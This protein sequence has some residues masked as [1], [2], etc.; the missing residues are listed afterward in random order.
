MT[1]S[2]FT[3]GDPASVSIRSSLV[4]G[5]IDEYLMG[6]LEV[7]VAGRPV[8]HS[9]VSFPLYEALGLLKWADADRGRRHAP[10]LAGRTAR[11]VVRVIDGNMA[12]RIAP[13]EPDHIDEPA[14]FLVSP[15]CAPFDS[16]ALFLVG[17][18]GDRG[19]AIA[20]DL[21]SDEVWE[22]QVRM[23]HIEAGLCRLYR[24]ILALD[25]ESLRRFR[26]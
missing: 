4:G 5:V 22:A 15:M 25:E 11:E 8:G 6:T 19:R 17:E 21:T 18:A 26:R 20:L 23:Q 1:A 7:T 3:F 10:L 16:A 13:G 14:R 2:V 12:R 9:T 24:F